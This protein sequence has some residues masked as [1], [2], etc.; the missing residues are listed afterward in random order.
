LFH[1]HVDYLMRVIPVLSSE[2]QQL[3]ALIW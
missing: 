2:P 1:P 3:L